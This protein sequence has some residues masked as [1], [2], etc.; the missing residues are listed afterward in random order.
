MPPSRSTWIFIFHQVSTDHT[1]TYLIG[2]K[3]FERSILRWAQMSAS[4]LKR[5]WESFQRT[6]RS[7]NFMPICHCDAM[8]GAASMAGLRPHC[9]HAILTNFTSSR[10]RPPLQAFKI[11][12]SGLA[13]RGGIQHFFWLE[14]TWSKPLIPEKTSA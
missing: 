13:P 2:I 5:P 4:L 1:H 14:I 10:V 8:G 9:Q 12:A 11:V 3:R 6:R 7:L